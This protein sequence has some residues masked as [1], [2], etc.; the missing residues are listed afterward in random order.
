MTQE[1][2]FTENVLCKQKN[3][4]QRKRKL[5]NDKKSEKRKEMRLYKSCALVLGV[6]THDKLFLN[7]AAQGKFA[8]QIEAAS[9][10]PNAMD[11]LKP[12]LHTSD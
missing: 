1:H 5:E 10:N 2:N 3:K 9:I 11:D 7:D 4:M 8:F 6:I 12:K